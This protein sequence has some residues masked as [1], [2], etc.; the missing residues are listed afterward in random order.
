[1]IADDRQSIQ[2][3]LAELERE[4]ARMYNPLLRYDVTEP[5]VAFILRATEDERFKAGFWHSGD[6]DVLARR[7][8][9]ETQPSETRE[10]IKWLRDTPRSR[11]Q[12]IAGR[13]LHDASDKQTAMINCCTVLA[14]LFL[15]DMI[16]I[17]LPNDD[18][19]G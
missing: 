19:K 10:Y 2:A 4:K 7:E 8:S 18:K 14:R 5:V 12:M 1:M 16:E 3:R 15:M 13:R 9:F 17:D 11:V 6:Q